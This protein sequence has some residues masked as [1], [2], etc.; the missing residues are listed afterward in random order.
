MRAGTLLRMLLLMT[1][2]ALVGCKE[3]GKPGMKNQARGTSTS[4]MTPT[5]T[6]AWRK[7]VRE[8]GTAVNRIL[9]D[10]EG[11]VKEIKIV[12]KYS[13]GGKT[14]YVLDL[15]TRRMFWGSPSVVSGGTGGPL[16]G[17]VGKPE[18]VRTYREHLGM[19]IRKLKAS[20]VPAGQIAILQGE[21][22]RTPA[23]K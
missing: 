1:P 18:E 11:K 4:E 2:L 10:G 3:P 5:S 6:R 7:P 19:L 9:R 16:G 17:A 12:T 8:L 14:F 21:L 22:D 20:K 23:P 13:T 15:Q